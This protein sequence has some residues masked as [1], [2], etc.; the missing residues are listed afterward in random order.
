MIITKTPLRISFAGGG[1]DIPSFYQRQEGIVVS[2]GI[3][4]S[5]YLALHK[6]FE[7]KI[8][9]KYSQTEIVD[10]V[11]EIQHKLIRECLDISG[12]RKAIEITSFS[13]IPSRGTGLGSSSAFAVG[14]IYALHAYQG[15][16]LTAAQCA[17]LACEV[18]IDRLG[19]PIGKQDQYT[20]AFGG[21]NCFRFL[22]DGEV[23]VDPIVLEEAQVKE[24]EQ[25]L[26]LFYTGI[27]R[28]ASPILWDQ[29]K[30][31]TTQQAKFG[32]L[33]EMKALAW[34]LK[35]LLEAGR[36]DA[37]GKIMHAGWIKKR[38]LTDQISNPQIDAWYDKA[39]EA[40]AVGGKLLGAGGGGF[41]IF[42]CPLKRQAELRKSLHDIREVEFSFNKKGAEIVYNS[43]RH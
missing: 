32:L 15:K 1:T 7:S 35:K 28:S 16:V 2:C 5:V 21:W 29:Q 12:V 20:S 24:M 41:L 3:D 40:G 22:P 42:D 9:L 11:S 33:V 25:R 27:I 10:Q 39:L 26:L 43:D 13:D 17:S 30:Q 18:E 34:E 8:V 36:A 19:D 14:L 23:M 38:Q 31:I 4:L 37:L 6:F